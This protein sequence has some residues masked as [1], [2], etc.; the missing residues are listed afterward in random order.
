MRVKQTKPLDGVDFYYPDYIFTIE[1]VG[2]S[3]INFTN[4][5]LGRGV[6]SREDFEKNF[7]EVNEINGSEMVNLIGT[8][9]IQT[10]SHSTVFGDFFHPSDVFEILSIDGEGR[11]RIGNASNEQFY[12][13]E[14]VLNH[15]FR[16]LPD[17][18]AVIVECEKEKTKQNPCRWTAWKD[19]GINDEVV[20]Y[21]TRNT[22]TVQVKYKGHKRSA[23]CSHGDT[24]DVDVGIKLAYYRAKIDCFFERTAAYRKAY[25]DLCE[26]DSESCT[27]E[28]LRLMWLTYVDL[29]AKLKTEY[30]KYLKEVNSP[31]QIRP[32]LDYE[33]LNKALEEMRIVLTDTE[34]NVK[35]I[36]SIMEDVE[37]S[38]KNKEEN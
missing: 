36:K 38:I 31:K 4:E 35:W 3:S 12:I 11:I 6:C 5:N 15:C 2:T 26:K 7:Q 8:K 20:E 37:S 19:Y 13:D 33:Y 27:A 25:N 24:F 17:D 14:G 18:L 28:E 22:K 29:T 23:N 34:K 32:E 30:E 1:K 10:K 9:I 16:S 21:R